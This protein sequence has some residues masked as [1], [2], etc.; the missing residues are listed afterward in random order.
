MREFAKISCS[1]WGSK[2]FKSLPDEDSRLVY[3]YLHTSPHVNSLGCY[4]LPF[5]YALA[6]LGWNN[7]D[8]DPIRYRKAIAA[9]CDSGLIGFDEAES[10]VRIVDFLKHSPFTNEK[11]AKGALKI[12][13]HIPSCAEKDALI[14]DLRGMKHVSA[15]LLPAV[16]DSLSDSLSK[17]CRYT[18]TE[19]DTDTER[20][21]GRGNAQARDP[22]SDQP[23][24]REQLLDAMGVDPSGLT[25]PSGK[26]IGQRADLEL[27]DRW[28]SDLKLSPETI[29]AVIRETMIGKSDGQPPTSFKYFNRSMEREAARQSEP[30]LQPAP[31]NEVNHDRPTTSDRREA[32][33]DEA[34]RRRLAAAARVD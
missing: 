5:G 9:L 10:V 16:A 28:M 11:H 20:F 27:A 22:I 26:V 15:Q 18:E 4:V 19:T 8:S 17:P 3:F 12:L 30:R 25:G 13:Y 31:H 33:A 7:M 14:S 21:I 29:L 2:K 32:A 1:I 24:W 23:T 34:L 6:D